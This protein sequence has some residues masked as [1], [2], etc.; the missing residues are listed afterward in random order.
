MRRRDRQHREYLQSRPVRKPQVWRLLLFPLVLLV[1]VWFVYNLSNITGYQHQSHSYLYTRSHLPLTS[2][3]QFDVRF[4]DLNLNFDFPVDS[5]RPYMAG[6]VTIRFTSRVE[7]LKE[8]QLDFNTTMRVDSVTGNSY[9]FQF[10]NGILTIY[11]RHPLAQ[12]Q[13]DAVTIYYHGFPAQYHPW[14]KG[15]A[16]TWRRRN[17]YTPVPWVNTMNPP[18][19]AQTWFPCKDVP[20]DKAD[21]ATI[22][23]TVPDTLL[24][25][26]NGL[27]AATR[28]VGKGRKQYIWKTRYPIAPYLIAVNIGDYQQYRFTYT[29]ITGETFPIDFYHF[30]EDAE[31]LQEVQRQMYRMMHFFETHLG[32]YPFRKEKYGMI[33]YN[34]SGGM[35]NQTISSIQT[36]SPARERLFAHELAHQ[37]IGNWVTN[38]SFHQSFLNEGMATYLTALY[39]R[40][41][42]GDSAF[43]AY[44]ERMRVENVGPILVAN[45]QVPDSVYS[46]DRVYFKG[47]WF[48]RMV[49]EI[50]GERAFWQALRTVLN[51]HGGGTIT[52]AD[53]LTVL[54]PQPVLQEF[55]NSWLQHPG[56]PQLYLTISSLKETERLWRYRVQVRQKNRHPFV[57][58][59]PLVFNTRDGMVEK[60]FWVKEKQ[61][62][63]QVN[64]NSPLDSIHVANRGRWLMMVTQQ[65]QLP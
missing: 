22:R 52:T 45:I 42:H 29:S 41:L 57:V 49:H 17:D 33:L 56:I 58:Q 35:E 63:F 1:L 36:F 40:S 14:V 5:T 10:K 59:L 54:P 15:L 30:H 20:A 4:Y 51:T 24:A 47:A 2:Q 53:F 37:W 6:A 9:R 65:W 44:M 28:A 11:L 19:A 16:F 50:V 48:F 62:S 38:A 32:P 23:I 34:N 25:V 8:I 46:T 27:L 26:S 43:V 31:V 64:L 55:F 21:S 18:F 39:W 12:G 7:T 3:K 60:K 61:E 13:T